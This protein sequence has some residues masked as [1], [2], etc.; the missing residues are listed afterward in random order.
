MKSPLTGMSD[1]ER[2]AVINPKSI[3]DRWQ[4]SMQINI[5][6]DFALL[7]SI[8]YWH[9]KTTGLHWYTPHEAAGGGG[10]YT[11]LEKN[12]WYYMES[13]WEHQKAL[14]ELTSGERVLEVGVGFG[15]FLKAAKKQGAQAFGVELN[16]SAAKRVRDMG[17]EIYETDLTKL[18]REIDNLFDVVCAFQ[19]LEHVSEPREFLEGMLG[20][21]RPGGRMIL[22]VP[23]A[24][25][26]RRIDPSNNDL[27]N[28][29]PH[30]MTHWDAGVFRALE[31]LLPVRVLAI[32]DEPLADYHVDWFVTG[33][34]RGLF[35][36]L[37]TKVNRLFFNRVTTAPIRW[38]MRQGL[39]LR[40]PG[41]TVLVVFEKQM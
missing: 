36:P 23:N 18:S 22:S 11:Q 39:R 28:Q 29:P 12:D 10:L 33:F 19:V 1:T 26:M 17:F 41:H 13:K 34:L 3:S 40:I 6:R 27:L 32:Y 20:V 14:G 16:P 9:C 5:G 24:A 4:D 25:V 31:Q 7:P 38:L 21:L 2:L 8:E 35:A 15:Y 30:H 37:G